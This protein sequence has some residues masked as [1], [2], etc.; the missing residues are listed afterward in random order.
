MT[1]VQFDQMLSRLRA[2]EYSQRA[3]HDRFHDSSGEVAL[4]PV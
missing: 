1:R 2:L 4:W 3:H